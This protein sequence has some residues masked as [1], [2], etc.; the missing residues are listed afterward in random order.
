MTMPAPAMPAIQVPDAL[1]IP[2]VPWPVI[3][4]RLQQ[5]WTV[6]DAPHHSVIAQTRA[7]KSYLTRHGILSTCK[8]DKV[9][10]IDGKG[11][12][13]TLDGFGRV[14]KRF[15]TK[16]LRS[17]KQLFQDKKPR[18]NWF[19]LVTSPDWDQAREQAL[20][21]LERVFREGDWIVVVDEL[22]YLVDAREPGLGLRSRWEQINLRGGSAGVGLV[23]LTQEPA[24]VPSSF[25]TQ[26]SFY[27]FSR[28]Q[29]ERALKR[30]AEIGVSRELF[31]F[32]KRIPRRQWIYM[33][34]LEDETFWAKTRV[35][36]P[37]R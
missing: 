8:W 23:S 28:V 24:W 15:P 27:W 1:V 5:L 10:I 22:R 20:E 2:D 3:Q 29:D 11:S 35:T 21:A 6:R 16:S 12:D 19:R 26:S 7:G 25:Y 9:L 31:P 4:S 32:L 34:N 18:E 30:I 37:T 33:D 14:I 13:P 36:G 17:A